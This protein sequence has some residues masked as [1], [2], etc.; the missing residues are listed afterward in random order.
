MTHQN[1]GGLLVRVHG[2]GSTM[3]EKK[4]RTG[5]CVLPTSR[6]RRR[7]RLSDYPENDLYKG[8]PLGPRG[9]GVSGLNVP[10]LR[11]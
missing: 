4:G 9:L 7:D 5:I 10:T 11:I 6:D 1:G 2:D 8:G 3:E